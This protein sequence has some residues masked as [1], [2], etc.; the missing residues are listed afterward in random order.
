MIRRTQIII[1]DDGNELE[2]RKTDKR[3]WHRHDARRKKKVKMS[4]ILKPSVSPEEVERWTNENPLCADIIDMAAEPNLIHV[5]SEL[6]RLQ[7]RVV[8]GQKLSGRSRRWLEEQK[9]YLAQLRADPPSM[10]KD[11]L[12][13]LGMAQSNVRIHDRLSLTDTARAILK[14]WRVQRWVSP[15]SMQILRSEYKEEIAAIKNPKFKKNDLVEI[16]PCYLPGARGLDPGLA[17]VSTEPR[18]TLGRQDSREHRYTVSYGVI[19]LGLDGRVSWFSESALILKQKY[20]YVQD[21]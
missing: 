12:W 1:D 3:K 10:T 6:H 17:L 7:N 14:A 15:E 11:D 20:A 21:T 8:N 13:V 16:N 9:E 18:L 4:Q 19:D 2:I 5:R